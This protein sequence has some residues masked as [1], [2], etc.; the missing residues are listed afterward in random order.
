MQW[1]RPFSVYVNLEQEV[2]SVWAPGPLTQPPDTWM[3]PG[4]GV[5]KHYLFIYLLLSIL[6]V[7]HTGDNKSPQDIKV[8]HYW[9]KNEYNSSSYNI[10]K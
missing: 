9:N 10:N 7:I 2:N 1:I 3:L 5:I 4:G 8:V 6:Q